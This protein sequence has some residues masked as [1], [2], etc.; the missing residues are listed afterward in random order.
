MARHFLNVEVGA[1]KRLSSRGTERIKVSSTGI[2]IVMRNSMPHSGKFNG[3]RGIFARKKARKSQKTK[4]SG[5][6]LF[7]PHSGAK[8]CSNQCWL[9]D[10]DIEMFTAGLGN[11]GDG[12]S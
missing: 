4:C 11:V 12:I 9:G 7:E 6:K 3:E 10:M 2:G 8:K 5:N 1:I